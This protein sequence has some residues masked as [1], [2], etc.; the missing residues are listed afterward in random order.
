MNSSKWIV[1]LSL[2][3][4]ANTACEQSDAEDAQYDGTGAAADSVD[5]N[6]A[7]FEEVQDGSSPTQLTRE[8]ALRQR[9]LDE[10]LISLRDLTLIVPDPALVELGRDLFF[11]PILGGELDVACSTCHHPQLGFA[12]N[13]DFPIGVGGV[14]LGA[15]RRYTAV[16]HDNRAL[17]PLRPLGRSSPTVLNLQLLAIEADARALPT[18]FLWDGR[19]DE[20]SDFTQMP[21][22]V[23]DEMR[24]DAWPQLDGM[25]GLLARL[26]EN[27]AWRAR[28]EETFDLDSEAPLV[29]SHMQLAFNAFMLSLVSPPNALDDFL[30]GSA[31]PSEQ[32]LN[33]LELFMDLSCSGCH[34]GVSMSD[35]G[36]H[37]TGVPV[38]EL[39]RPL[40]GGVDVGRMEPTGRERDRYLF[41]TG[42]LREI[43]HT[44]PYMHNGTL[45]TL[46][47]VVR[48]YVSGTNP[49]AEA[50]PPVPDE[51]LERGTP[52]DLTDNEVADLV[53]FLESLS[54]PAGELERLFPEPDS[55]PSLLPPSGVPAADRLPLAR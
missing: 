20:L 7:T 18:P 52:R 1:L 39:S 27:D 31:A 16:A 26:S 36:F 43:A 37:L 19:A 41:R 47:D 28:F 40:A 46:E 49:L 5:G 32:F 50:L 29:L 22:T 2:A 17:G 33:G 9:A 4:T 38:G 51:R 6:D 12:D 34:N 53:H 30:E 48:F 23:R 25:S 42:P 15:D 14:G 44:A 11:D 24:G 10:G 8:S 45:E 55:V 21:I 54:S 35:G 3:A 13:V